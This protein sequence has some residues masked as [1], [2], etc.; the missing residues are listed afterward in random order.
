M[1][2][3]TLALYAVAAVCAFGSGCSSLPQDHVRVS[4][5]PVFCRDDERVWLLTI[6]TRNSEKFRLVGRQFELWGDT[7]PSEGGSRKRCIANVWLV[8][9]QVIHGEQSYFK[10]VVQGGGSTVTATREG[11]KEDELSGVVDVTLPETPVVHPMN[12]PVVVGKTG[13]EY[14]RLTV[15]PAS[16]E[17][18]AEQARFSEPGDYVPA[19]NRSS[20]APG[21]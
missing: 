11:A 8:G 5:K 15:R 21:R 9:S 13:D 18:N 17:G 14:M 3:Y 1:R 4:S 6:E 19:T 16:T 12:R 10:T 7:T 20:L 2:N